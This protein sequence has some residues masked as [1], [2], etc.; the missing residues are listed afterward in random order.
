[1]Q[2]A[3]AMPGIKSIMRVHFYSTTAPGR[4]FDP[5][6]CSKTSSSGSGGNDTKYC[7]QSRFYSCAANI[8]CPIDGGD[9]DCPVED[10]ANLAAFLPCAEAS[11]PSGLSSF[12]NALPCAKQHGLNVAK[13]L[14]CYDPTDVSYTGPAIATIDAVGNATDAAR[15]PVVKFYPDVRVAGKQ[16]QGTPTA[17]KLTKA[18]CAAYA[19]SDP[20]PACSSS[21]EQA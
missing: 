13:I 15:D 10:M 17:E 20:P 4:V 2:L 11:G 18:V 1:M 21:V 8:H 9:S 14:S 6:D 12:S 19:G 16:L 3:K 7:L 5:Y